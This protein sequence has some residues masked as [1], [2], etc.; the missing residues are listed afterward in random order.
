MKGSY[1]VVIMGPSG[2]AMSAVIDLEKRDKPLSLAIDDERLRELLVVNAICAGVIEAVLDKGQP[3][4]PMTTTGLWRM[5]PSATGPV[6]VLEQSLKQAL[7]EVAEQ[8]GLQSS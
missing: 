2:V 1:S 5:V 7:E 4:D 3:A 6:A 8:G